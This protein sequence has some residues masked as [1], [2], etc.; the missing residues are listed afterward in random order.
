MAGVETGTL[1]RIIPEANRH[2]VSI[3]LA[4]DAELAGVTG[5]IDI[6]TPVRGQ[7]DDWHAVAIRYRFAGMVTVHILGRQLN[8]LRSIT[9]D[10]VVMT[11]DR[12]FVRTR[13][14]LYRL[15]QPAVG[16]PS[17]DMVRH[18]ERALLHWIR[19]RCRRLGISI[20][21]VGRV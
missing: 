2:L 7:I 9:S 11:P 8:A 5:G 10:I 16:E 3:G 6:L 13:N 17:P 1:D 19:E 15:V 20:S 14:S 21:E 4:R 12:R 18:V